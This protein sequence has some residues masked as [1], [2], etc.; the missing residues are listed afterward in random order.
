MGRER[1]SAKRPAFHKPLRCRQPCAQRQANGNANG[2][3]WVRAQG[4]HCKTA[5][6]RANGKVLAWQMVRVNTVLPCAPCARTKGMSHSSSWPARKDC[7]HPAAGPP[8][9]IA[10]IQWLDRPQGIPFSSGRTETT[11]TTETAGKWQARLARLATDLTEGTGTTGVS[12]V[13]WTVNGLPVDGKWTSMD[14][15]CNAQ[16]ARCPSG[17]YSWCEAPPRR[18]PGGLG[19]PGGPGSRH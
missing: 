15:K 4:A 3:P 7:H 5:C 9:R 8:A 19:G 18:N 12:P 13:A 11:G 14:R 16:D 6:T 10:A 17:A 2:V 1:Q